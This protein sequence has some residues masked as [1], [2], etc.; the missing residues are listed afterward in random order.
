M[1]TKLGASGNFG[2]GFVQGIKVKGQSSGATGITATDSSSSSTMLLHSV[3]GT[4]QA[5]ETVQVF[6]DSSKTKA[7]DSLRIYAV[8]YTH[9]TL[10][11][12][13]IV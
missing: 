3:V 9:L 7:T 6:N 11:T 13:R 4:F 8:S 1:F 10:P 5:N 2:S 12:K